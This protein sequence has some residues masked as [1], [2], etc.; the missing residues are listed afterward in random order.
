ML[1]F[2]G[3]WGQHH[4]QLQRQARERRFGLGDRLALAGKEKAPS[5]Q[6]TPKFPVG[7]H[8]LRTRFP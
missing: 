2:G 1:V 3:M 7:T 5:S 6:R 8:G 4:I